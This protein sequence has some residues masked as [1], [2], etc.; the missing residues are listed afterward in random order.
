[1]EK[2][3]L[4]LILTAE[5]FLEILSGE[6]KT[7]YRSF[8]DY[9]ISRLCILDKDG[10]ID[11]YKEIETIRF[12]LGYR[13]DR[14]ELVIENKGIFIEHDD[15]EEKEFLTTE[16]CEFAIDLGEILS[17]KNCEELIIN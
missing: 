14:P 13:K 12:V 17:T 8:S 2:K 4:L 7:E 10:E 6:K 15:D 1:M 9:Y 3:E 11:G 16:N 5:F